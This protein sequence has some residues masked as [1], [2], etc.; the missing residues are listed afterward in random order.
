MRVGILDLLGKEPP[1]N[2]YSRVW[3][4]N[5]TSIMPQVVA[6]WCE[7]EGHDVSMAYYSGHERIA[8][9]L[10]D[11]L[12]LLFIS[13]FSQAALVAY[14]FSQYF[15]SKGVV[16]VL[17]GPHARSY[18]EDAQ[19]YFDYVVG[20][21]DKELVRD[22]L[23]DCSSYPSLGQHIAAKGQPSDLPGLE[24]RWKFLEP[25]MEQA[26]MI[27]AVPMIGSLGCPY[28]CSFCVDAV[29]PYQPLDFE[30]LTTDLRFFLDRRLPRSFIVWHDPNFGVRF[31]HYLD[32]IQQAVPSGSIKFVAE[33]S[34]SLLGEENVKR[35]R[36]SGFVSILPGIES[37]YDIG[38][39]SRL[40]KVTGM[41]RVRRVADQLN[42]VHS[43][44]PYVQGNLIF[45]LDADEGAEPFELAKRFFDLAPGIY[46]HLAV[47]SAFGRNAVS[48]LEYQRADRVIAVP[49]H[50]LDLLQSMNVKPKHYT[51]TEFYDHVCDV[52]AYAFSARA[53]ARRFAANENT[54][55]RFEQL[56][57]GLTAE[58]GNRVRVH[59]NMRQWLDEPDFRAFFEG[60]THRI[61]Q[62][63]VD[64]IRQKMG[65]LWEWLPEGA[66][67][68]DPNAFLESGTGH[69]LTVLTAPHGTPHSPK[70][71]ESALSS[72]ER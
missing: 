37:W 44:I 42:M 21:C 71:N 3:R 52:F 19:K 36:H 28:T 56:F 8:G 46:P 12:D 40:R 27:R 17:G 67:D 29:V 47:L 61:P 58:I 33:S 38:E 50:F 57:R 41:A 64:I 39:K 43:Y 24:E 51:W 20:L 15:R 4:A 62:R 59:R 26:K 35:L 16:T 60:E 25:A 66:L 18:P 13:A 65:W 49:F 14:A 54:L 48:N 22:I 23:Q 34:L 11:D 10:P 69:P 5:A 6:V 9:A 63:F 30:T 53:M 70:L 2:A 7:Q 1:K 31:N 45:G 68:Y 55:I 72:S 32:A